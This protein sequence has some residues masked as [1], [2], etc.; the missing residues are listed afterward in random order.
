M[1]DISKKEIHPPCSPQFFLITA[2]GSTKLLYSWELNRH[3]KQTTLMKNPQCQ[4][5][6]YTDFWARVFLAFKWS[7]LKVRIKK[8]HRGG[9]RCFP[10][11]FDNLASLGGGGGEFL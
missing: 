4:W 8:Q 2:P 7:K 1:Q 10:H 6:F 11:R 3:L 5:Y 9:R